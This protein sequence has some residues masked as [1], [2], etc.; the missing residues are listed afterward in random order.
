MKRMCAV[1]H[2]TH[3]EMRKL[4]FCS[5]SCI[6]ALLRVM[7]D[8]DGKRIEDL[9]ADVEQLRKLCAD[10]PDPKNSV[11]VWTAWALKVKD[12]VAEWQKEDERWD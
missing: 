3:E 1:C 6:T 4:F 12:R 10:I 9:E 8:E 7:R 11:R 2:K 5:D